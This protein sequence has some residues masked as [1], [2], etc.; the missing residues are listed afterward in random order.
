MTAFLKK[1]NYM[2]ENPIQSVHF[3]IE[4]KTRNSETKVKFLRNKIL[5]GMKYHQWGAI[6][7]RQ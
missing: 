3:T 7:R 6:L 1:T 4:K 5:K 2:L